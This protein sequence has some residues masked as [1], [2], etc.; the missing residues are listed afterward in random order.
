[1]PEA[2]DDEPAVVLWRLNN[3]FPASRTAAR[4]FAL[5]RKPLT[6]EQLKEIS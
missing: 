3:A 2:K 4:F 6:C 1:M 5:Q